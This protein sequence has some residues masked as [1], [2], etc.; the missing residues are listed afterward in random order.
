MAMECTICHAVVYQT[1][2]RDGFNFCPTCRSLFRPVERQLP[3]WILGVLVFLIGNL[4]IIS[5]R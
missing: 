4:Q 2:N 3:T 5:Q 1:R